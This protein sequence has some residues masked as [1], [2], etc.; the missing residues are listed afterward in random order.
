MSED[1]Q[2]LDQRVGLVSFV[3]VETLRMA[4]RCR[5]MYEFDAVA[6]LGYGAA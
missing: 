2:Y 6:V 5:N 3:L 4:I 1:D